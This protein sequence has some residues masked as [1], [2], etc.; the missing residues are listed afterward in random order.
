MESI[1]TQNRLK[2]TL[3]VLLMV[4]LAI[5]VMVPFYFMIVSSFK[6]VSVIFANGINVNIDFSKM[7]FDNYK[8]LWTNQNGI[9]WSWYKNSLVITVVETVLVLVFTSMV[10]YGLAQYDFK[11]RKFIFALVLVMMMVPPSILLLP[12]YKLVTQLGLMDSYAGVI[13]PYVVPASSI[14]FF[15]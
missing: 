6:D 12:L 11:G 9:Y 8:S 7:N 15:R 14:F 5:L 13:L 1:K 3:S 10:G 2:T 4:F